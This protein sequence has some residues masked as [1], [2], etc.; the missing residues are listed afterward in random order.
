MPSKTA[1]TEAPADA[2][3]DDG[4]PDETE[5]VNAELATTEESRQL[6]EDIIMGRGE[7]LEQIDD[8]ANA[9]EQIVR[10]ILEAP[11]EDAVLAEDSTIATK[12]LVGQPLEVRSFRLLKSQLV[13]KE[14]GEVRQGAFMIV[15]ATFGDLETGEVKPLTLN[16]G[17]PKIMAQLIR[18][19]QLDRLPAKV[20]VAEVGQAK[21][22]RNRAL[23]LVAA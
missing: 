1:K 18:L 22:G 9:Q 21:P 16:T 12:E 2:S 7:A 10:R 8:P 23:Q 4:F 20:K 6:T 11:D 17:A 19:Q 3:S 15:D 14:T 13:D 5:E